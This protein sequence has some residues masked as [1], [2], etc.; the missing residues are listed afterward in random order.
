MCDKKECCYINLITLN[1]ENEKVVLHY[2]KNGT[3]IFIQHNNPKEEIFREF[4]PKK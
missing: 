1:D 4:E 3:V 2:D